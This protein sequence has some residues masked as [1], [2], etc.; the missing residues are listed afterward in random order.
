MMNVHVLIING[1]PD[2]IRLYSSKQKL[3]TGYIDDLKKNHPDFLKKVLKRLHEYISNSDC[4]IEIIRALENKPY[5]IDLIDLSEYF[6]E[7]DPDT[8]YHICE[9]E[10][11]FD[12]L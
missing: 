11:P 4:R 12:K 3:F 2:H 5:D 1:S 10:L 9:L 6:F 8:E 7:F